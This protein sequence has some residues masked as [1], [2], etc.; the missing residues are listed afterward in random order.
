ME[1]LTEAM[2]EGKNNTTLSEQFH[3]QNRRKKQN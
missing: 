2:K 3:N 1:G